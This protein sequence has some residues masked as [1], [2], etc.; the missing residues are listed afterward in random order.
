MILV[1]GCKIVS[2]SVSQIMKRKIEQAKEEG[3]EEKIRE[4]E[5]WITKQRDRGVDFDDSVPLPRD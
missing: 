1:D 5:G 2:D 3:R 4:I